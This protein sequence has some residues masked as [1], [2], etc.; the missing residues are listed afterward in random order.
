MHFF[1]QL[2][3]VGFKNKNKLK[4]LR[5]NLYSK[6]HNNKQ[7]FLKLALCN[8]ICHKQL[9][10]DFFNNN[11]H[12]FKPY[13]NL[14]LLKALLISNNHRLNI[15]KHNNLFNHKKQYNQYH[16]SHNMDIICP[17]KMLYNMHNKYNN[18]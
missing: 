2:L 4:F 5:V 15:L 8:K 3:I 13:H 14:T 10:Q 16:N 9:R 17:N 11:R 7:T 12:L 18:N 6:I 1:N